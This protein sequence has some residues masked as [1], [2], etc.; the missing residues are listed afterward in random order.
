MTK[1][2][3]YN[4]QLKHLTTEFVLS[5][6][7]QALFDCNIN[8]NDTELVDVEMISTEHL[9][10]YVRKTPDLMA[11]ATKIFY[12]NG[13]TQINIRH[14]VEW[15]N[16]QSGATRTFAKIDLLNQSIDEVTLLKNLKAAI[17]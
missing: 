12:L 10:I 9:I 7:N 17:H 4:P 14:N 11:K 2:K 5:K 15:K 16:F 6:I 8:Y 1:E 3:V 13:T